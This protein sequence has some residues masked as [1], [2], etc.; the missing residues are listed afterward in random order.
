M[1]PPTVI[2][3]ENLAEQLPRWQEDDDNHLYAV[4]DMGSNGIRFS[5]TSLE[6]PTT[7]LLVP[8]YSTRAAISLFDALTPS[9]DGPIFPQ[10]T[11]EDVS[12][13]LARFRQL[14]IQH[15]VPQS[16]ILV[17]AT[18]AM[19]RAAN[20]EE[21]LAAIAAT[22]EGLQVKL[23]DPAV[24]TLFGAVMGSRSGLINVKGGAL[25][26]DLG[27]GSVQ[28]TWVD[29]DADEYAIEAADAGESLPYGAA[30]LTRILEEEP[31]EVQDREIE[32]L[33]DG[34]KRIYSNLCSRF[35]ALQAIRDAY[36]QGEEASVNVF[37]C[38]GGFR[39]YGSMLM[40][41]EKVSPYPISTTHAYSVT[42]DFF[43]RTEKMRR[44]NE[45]YDG[46]I[47]GMSK[48]RRRQ[49]PAIATVVE[50]FLAAVPNIGRVTFCGGSNRQ[51]ALMMT[52]P[53]PV[54][55]SDPLDV[56][57]EIE[58]DER[59]LFE[60]TQELLSSAMP[61]QLTSSTSLPTIFTLGLGPLLVCEI[62]NRTGHD[63]ST[64]SAF[65]LRTATIR[66]SD[67]PGLSHLARAILGLCTCARWGCR[68][69][70]ADDQLFEGLRSIADS[71]HEMASFWAIYIGAVSSTIASLFAVMPD[72]ATQL[73]DTIRFTTR[74]ISRDK[75]RDKVVLDIGISSDSFK[76][77]DTE[78]LAA[79]F[80][81][82]MSK[83]GDKWAPRILVDIS[84]LP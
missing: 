1:S 40:H 24:E 55:E 52:L 62:W 77:I 41:N 82:I 9:P 66:D 83:Q 64:N 67:C 69:S 54:R 58:Q 6:P 51:G 38:G 60:A 80:E 27:G 47:F 17:L 39:G 72:E 59:Q 44:V 48:R 26:L 49:F 68:T 32:K 34:I 73:K 18:E 25:F 19:R 7:R 63:A 76:G 42:G 57:C 53:P 37:M 4:V 78:K 29:T 84:V 56:L 20:A 61:K 30:K 21:M 31:P 28:M 35:S 33:N 8:V 12:S 16:N 15:D 45:E 65:A 2:T 10:E 46:K 36:E 81:S 70:P 75:K 3:L 5:I 22:T 23:L 74:V 50:A 14:A 71:Y 11:I 13:T 43:S 79:D